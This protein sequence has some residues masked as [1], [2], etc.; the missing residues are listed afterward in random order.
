MSENGA[1]RDRRRAKAGVAGFAL[2]DLAVDLVLPVLAYLALHG[3]GVRDYLALTAGGILVGGKAAL[4]PI[5]GWRR[6]RAAATTLGTTLAALALLAGLAAAGV[7]GPVAAAAAGLLIA[8]PVLRGL[9]GRGGPVDG[10][11]LLVLVEVAASVL[12]TLVSGDP[13]WLLARP[14]VYLAVAGGYALV[15]CVVGRPLMLDASKPMA[16]AGDPERAV[17]FENAWLRSARFR[18]VERAMTVGLGVLMLA[19]AVLRV[20]L[21][22]RAPH[23]DLARLGL[24][25]QLPGVALLVLFVLAVKLLA[26]PR[27]REEVQRELVALR[28][29]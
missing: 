8:V 18:R 4:G 14:S 6:D 28:T 19:E 29:G 12:V 9:L 23:G 2:V 10:M 16:V 17:A 11:G 3:L 5:H 21:V 15:S 27:A 13:R 26:V 24:L 25:V 7:P 22:Y 1:E 20:V